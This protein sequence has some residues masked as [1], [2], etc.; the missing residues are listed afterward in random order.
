MRKLLLAVLLLS[1]SCTNP[2]CGCSPPRFAVVLRGT[3]QD[4][5]GAPIAAQRIRS[6]TAYSGCVDYYSAASSLTTAD[7]RFSFVVDAPVR[8]SVCVRFF[9]RDTVAGAVESPVGGV[10]RVKGTEFPWDTVDV[11][12]TLAPVAR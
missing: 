11:P 1:I 2:L 9:A 5:E 12:L 7:G 10:L 8:D 6:E 3:L 4:S